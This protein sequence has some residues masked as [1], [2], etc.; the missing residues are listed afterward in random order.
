MNSIWQMLLGLPAFLAIFAVKCYQWIISPWLGP[1]CRFWPTCSTYFIESVRK[2]GAL[3][4]TLRGV[5]RIC[6]CHPWS[7][8]GDDPP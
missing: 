7:A 3:W 2:H 6:R 8:G 4:G 1:R 5:R